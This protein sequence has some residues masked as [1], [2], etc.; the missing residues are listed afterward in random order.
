MAEKKFSLKN[1]SKHS[2][3]NLQ[4]SPVLLHPLWFVLFLIYGSIL[5]SSSS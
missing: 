4:A 5:S 2:R 1:E 3:R